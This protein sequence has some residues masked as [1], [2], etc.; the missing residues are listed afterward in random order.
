MGSILAYIK[1]NWL[2]LLI[3]IVVGRFLLARFI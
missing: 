3:G 1:A 2:V